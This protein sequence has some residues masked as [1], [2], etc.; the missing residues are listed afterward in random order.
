[1]LEQGR[2]AAIVSIFSSQKDRRNIGVGSPAQ[3]SLCPP[4]HKIV[5]DKVEAVLAGHEGQVALSS[6][7]WML[8]SAPH[9]SRVRT[10]PKN[11]KEAAL[12]RG[13]ARCVD[14][15]ASLVCEFG[16]DLYSSRRATQGSWPKE[17][18]LNSA[19]A[20]SVVRQVDVQAPRWSSRRRQDS[21]PAEAQT[22]RAV[23]FSLIGVS[24]RNGWSG[25]LE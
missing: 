8:G 23:R 21:C 1:M 10:Q 2:D 22:K 13:V 6:N 24:R 11:P 17:A 25:K 15:S 20:P 16:F 7:R 9:L 18:A 19:V 3:V 5:D 14:V 4:L 12:N